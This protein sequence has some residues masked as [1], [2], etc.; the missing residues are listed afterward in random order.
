MRRKLGQPNVGFDPELMQPG[1]TLVGYHFVAGTVAYDDF[2]KAM[3]ED[4]GEDIRPFLRGFY[5][6]LRQWRG[7]DTSGMSSVLEIE[8]ACADAEGRAS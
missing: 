4:L 5:E 1:F 3:I 6:S 8:K 7:L 2:V